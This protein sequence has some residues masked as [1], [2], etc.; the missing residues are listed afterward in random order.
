M[1]RGE[2]ENC[3]RQPLSQGA[4][5]RVRCKTGRSAQAIGRSRGGWT[6]KVHALID[7]IGRP[8][9]LMLAA[10]NVSDV[11][12]APALLKAGRLRYLLADKGYDADQLRRSLRDAGAVPVIPGRRSRKR[13]LLRQGTLS[14][15]SPIEN[16]FLPPQG[17]PPRPRPLRQLAANFLPDVALAIAIAFG[18]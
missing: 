9:T 12:A 5:G 15:P 18:L 14:R 1:P 3:H 11:K 4:G 6:T 8:Y 7:V 13:H 2:E 10:G 17:L 16:A